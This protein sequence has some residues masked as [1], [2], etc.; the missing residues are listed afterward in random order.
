MNQAVQAPPNTAVVPAHIAARIA[1]RG[2]KRSDITSAVATGGASYPRISIKA[3]RFRLVEDAVET[4]VGINMDVVIVGANPKVSKIYY[5][6]A[7]T[8]ADNVRPTCFSDDGITPDPS[9]T[10]VQAPN[11]AECPNNILGSKVNP[12]GAKSKKC[13]DQRHLAVVPAADP[14]KVYGIAVTVTA[15]KGLRE[16]FKDLENY[17]L[18]PEEVITTLGFDDQADYPKLTFKQKEGGFVPEAALP[19]IEKI[20]ASD[21]VKVVTRQ[22]SVGANQLA[23]PQQSAALPAA[24]PPAYQPPQNLPP[25]AQAPVQPPPNPPPVQAAPPAA[26]PAPASPLFAAPPPPAAAAAPAPVST[27]PAAALAGV[28]AKLAALFG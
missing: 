23:A 6:G 20:I 18:I 27:T 13:G 28:E 24:Q 22:K 14:N 26:A 9:G 19:M 4:M 3:S 10:T 16:Y 21:E 25:A 1:A 11:C 15:M 5:E 12:S 7:F 8:G 2:G 17:G